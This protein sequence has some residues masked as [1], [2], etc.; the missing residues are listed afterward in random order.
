M[1]GNDDSGGEQI[2]M[3]TNPTTTLRNDLQDQRL[4]IMITIKHKG[5][6]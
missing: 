6:F 3:L 4:V 1:E 5:N 2:D